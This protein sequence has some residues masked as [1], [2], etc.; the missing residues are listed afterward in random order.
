M[1]QSATVATA[2]TSGGNG[3]TSSSKT[4]QQQVSPW[5]F[6]WRYSA[7]MGDATINC[8]DDGGSATSIVIHATANFRSK[9]DDDTDDDEGRVIIFN[10]E[11]VFIKFSS[12]CASCCHWLIATTGRVGSTV[13]IHPQR[14]HHGLSQ[15]PSAQ[16]PSAHHRRCS[17]PQRVVAT[18]STHRRRRN[19][20]P[21]ILCHQLS[22]PLSASATLP[23]PRCRNQLPQP[24][25]SQ[26]RNY[27]TPTTG[28]VA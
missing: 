16:P 8:I 6:S 23:C 1:Q 20:P 26:H 24:P 27:L 12:L 22:Q 21:R 9:C 7:V 5:H 13:L 14:S 19:H 18:P 11:L 17:P 2:T 28:P 3:D 4:A 25:P 15:P 10:N